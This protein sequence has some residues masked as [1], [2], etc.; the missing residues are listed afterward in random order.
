MKKINSFFIIICLF[1]SVAFIGCIKQDN[2]PISLPTICD[3]ISISATP[4]WTFPGTTPTFK[5]SESKYIKIAVQNNQENEKIDVYLDLKVQ[6]PASNIVLLDEESGNEKVLAVQTNLKSI[7]PNG[8]VSWRIKVSGNNEAP[9][10][11]NIAILP[12]SIICSNITP[13]KIQITEN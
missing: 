4:E 8:T 9:G 1:L 6:S 3:K 7:G 11:Y 5:T 2:E 13:I 12:N 10:L